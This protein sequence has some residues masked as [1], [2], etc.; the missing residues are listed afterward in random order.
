MSYSPERLLARAGFFDKLLGLWRG[1]PE[2]A[3]T[4]RMEAWALRTAAAIAGAGKWLPP[5]ATAPRDGS[6]VLLVSIQPQQDGTTYI[7]IC[8]A[9]WSTDGELFVLGPKGSEMNNVGHA[10]ATHWLPMEW[11]TTS[12]LSE[13]QL[14][15][16]QRPEGER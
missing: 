11:L 10:C 13:G 3:E 7:N 2:Y 15:D 9:S 14:S 12:P 5:I 16:C 8:N 6:E 1:N 4:L